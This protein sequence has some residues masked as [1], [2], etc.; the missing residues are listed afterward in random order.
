[1][2]EVVK[3]SSWAHNL[4]RVAEDDGKVCQLTN[5]AVVWETRENVQEKGNERWLKKGRIYANECCYEGDG[6]INQQSR[7]H[8]SHDARRLGHTTKVGT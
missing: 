2:S 4:L 3:G 1:M 5:E 6:L 7:S 8:L